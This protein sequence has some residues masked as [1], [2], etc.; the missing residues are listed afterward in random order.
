M[1]WHTLLA[2]ASA[3][4]V[5]DLLF[6]RLDSA[7][8]AL[9]GLIGLAVLALVI[10]SILGASPGRRAVAMPALLGSVRGSPLAFVRHTPL[11]L[12]L[13]GLPLF[14]LALADPYTPLVRSDVSYKGRRIAM[15]IDA[16]SSMRVPFTAKQ[17]NPREETEAAFFTSVGAAQRFV[18]LRMKRKYRDLMALIEFGNEA[19][20]VTPFTNDYQNILLSISLIGDVVEFARFP[21][22]GTIIAQAIDQ[23]VQLFKAF[24]F[25]NASGNIMVIFSDGEDIHAIVNGRPLDDILAGAVEAHV[26]IYFIR[27]NYS[28][29]EGAIIPD[30]LWKH[31]VEKTGGK[32]FAASNEAAI[33]NAIAEIDRASTGAIDVKEYSTQEPRFQLFA[34]GAFALWGLAALLVLAV[35]HFRRFP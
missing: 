35:P 16:S 14:A 24:N 15:M 5:H 19:Y 21:D 20:V 28:K 4:R 33:L 10:R 17:L 3:L 29:G 31:A 8:L 6:S 18:Q 34:L 2:D 23:S 9:I 30:D 11:V 32:F 1:S 22:Q 7:R 12:F 13:A 25:L 26:P 27:T